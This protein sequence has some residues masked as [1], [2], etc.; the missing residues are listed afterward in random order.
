[1]T[2]RLQD[3]DF[4]ILREFDAATQDIVW[5]APKELGPAYMER[6]RPFFERLLANGHSRF[7]AADLLRMTLDAR[8][9][10]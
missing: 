2:Q 9:K 6:T 8:P 4:F 1:M 5:P 3:T 7:D 10:C